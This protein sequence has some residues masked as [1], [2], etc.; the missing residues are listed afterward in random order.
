MVM[1]KSGRGGSGRGV[2]LSTAASL[3]AAQSAAILT[4]NTA[5]SSVNEYCYEFYCLSMLILDA[6]CKLQLQLYN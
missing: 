6:V 1:N 5:V 3:S 2:N 4:S